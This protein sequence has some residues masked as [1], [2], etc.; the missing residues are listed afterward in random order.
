MIRTEAGKLTQDQ[1]ADIACHIYRV[2]GQLGV[3]WACERNS[4]TLECGLEFDRVNMARDVL[5]EDMWVGAM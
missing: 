5:V 1:A 4:V 3:R 2:C